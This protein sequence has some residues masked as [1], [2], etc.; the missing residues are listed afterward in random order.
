M[1]YANWLVA[2]AI[3]GPITATDVPEKS[4]T[5]QKNGIKETIEDRVDGTLNRL[6]SPLVGMITVTAKWVNRL[7]CFGNKM[8]IK[9]GFIY[10]TLDGGFAKITNIRPLSEIELKKEI[11]LNNNFP[12]IFI[13]PN[14]NPTTHVTY[15]GLVDPA[16]GTDLKQLPCIGFAIKPECKLFRTQN[17]KQFKLIYNKN[18][19]IIIHYF[20]SE[21]L[22]IECI[23]SRSQKIITRFA[24]YLGY[25]VDPDIPN[26]IH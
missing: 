14:I 7:H 17:P 4:T 26:T 16:P 9:N 6:D 5:L 22:N 8:N 24:W 3:I 19:Y 21:E 15:T 13:T 1:V 18:E 11:E 23:E 10:L 2:A 12:G 25:E 20:S